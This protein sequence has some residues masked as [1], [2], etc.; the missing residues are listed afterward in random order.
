[1]VGY[2]RSKLP[3]TTDIVLLGLTPRGV[4]NHIQPNAFT[5]PINAFNSKLK[6]VNC[7]RGSEAAAAAQRSAVAKM[8]GGQQQPATILDILPVQMCCC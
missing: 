4:G 6:W 7:S 2:L 1:M 5:A 8:P 3:P